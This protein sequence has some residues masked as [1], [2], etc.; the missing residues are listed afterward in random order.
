[1]QHARLE[2]HSEDTEHLILKGLPC[3]RDQLKRGGRVRLVNDRERLLADSELLSARDMQS[4]IVCGEC[5]RL[6]C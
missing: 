1:M 4:T 3:C 5:T 2:D 6:T